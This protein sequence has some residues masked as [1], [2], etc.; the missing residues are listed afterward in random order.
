MT[1]RER[2]E[3]WASDG[4]GWVVEAWPDGSYNHEGVQA[5]WEAWQ[6]SRRDALTEA[7]NLPGNPH[8]INRDAIRALREK[9]E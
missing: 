5:A 6:A 1:S 4:G 2:F 8:S 9:S 7:E 3:A